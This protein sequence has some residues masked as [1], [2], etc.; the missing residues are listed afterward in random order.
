MENLSAGVSEDTRVF[1]R[2]VNF[3]ILNRIWLSIYGKKG[4]SVEDLY[5]EIGITRNLYSKILSGYDYS[6][7]KL[8]QK[9]NTVM[10]I[11][12]DRL[13]RVMKGYERVELGEITEQDW[14]DYFSA[15]YNELEG[16]KGL[17]KSERRYRMNGFN[18]TLNKELGKLHGMTNSPA[19]LMYYFCKYGQAKEVERSP[20]F[21]VAEL[22][23]LL[24]NL[25]FEQWLSAPPSLRKE[26]L[27]L[28]R[29]Q[30][31]M[32]NTIEAYQ[33]YKENG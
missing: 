20:Y 25:T 11:M 14:K 8:D 2:R 31:D 32:V 17:S 30:V 15:R 28:L 13:E 4:K 1:N 16:D 9:W 24:P 23:N 26:L 6:G 12:G 27:L 3:F 21:R 22:K 10:S 29:K 5:D 19:D 7:K 18:G 33:H